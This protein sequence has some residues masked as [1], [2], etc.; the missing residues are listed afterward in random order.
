MSMIVST[1]CKIHDAVTMPYVRQALQACNELFSQLERKLYVD[2]YIRKIDL[3]TLK[4]R[5]ISQHGISGRHFNSIKNHLAGRVN[6]EKEL[7]QRDYEIKLSQAASTKKTISKLDKRIKELKG[8]VQSI[9]SY[10]AK[11]KEWRAS[12]KTKKMK[13]PKMP[14]KIRGL[15][16]AKLKRELIEALHRRHQKKRRLA[17]LQYKAAKL[18]KRLQRP[19][20]CFGS[21]RLLRKQHHLKANGYKTHG[22]W[23]NDWLFH[24]NS[25]SFWLGSHE[26][27]LRNQNAQYDLKTQRLSLRLPDAL[28]KAYGEYLVLDNVS[29]AHLSSELA[30]AMEEKREVWDKK[31]KESVCR[32][33]PISYRVLERKG[34]KAQKE[35][36][37][38]LQE[39]GRASC[40]E[41]V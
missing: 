17:C 40:R 1:T 16:H 5:Y 3:N 25:Q 6:A 15:E 19:A 13:K 2:Q 31:K 27:S 12:D 38:Y 36:K 18:D 23:R 30:S 34:L 8:L 20:L 7:V 21:R 22:E 29:F 11:V 14:P 33:V 10:K 4:S 9:L 41:R 28:A 39:I 37:F 35:S 26:E 32:H 24:R